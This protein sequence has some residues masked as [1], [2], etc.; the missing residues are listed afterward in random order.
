MFIKRNNYLVFFL[1][2]VRPAY[3]SPSRP[4]SG[5]YPYLPSA[6]TP[7]PGGDGGKTVVAVVKRTTVLPP[8]NRKCE[9]EDCVTC[10]WLLEVNT[11]VAPIFSFSAV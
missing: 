3:V 9:H 7:E 6:P 2:L 5:L 4:G 11:H 10:T 8:G 1:S